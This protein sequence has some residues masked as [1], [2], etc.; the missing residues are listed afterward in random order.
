MKQVIA[1]VAVLAMG[2][3]ASFA[4]NTNG[5]NARKP[6]RVPLSNTPIASSSGNAPRRRVEAGAATSPEAAFSAPRSEV[7]A[8]RGRTTRI[9][10]AAQRPATPMMPTELRQGSTT[11]SQAVAAGIAI[12]PR[13]P[14][15]L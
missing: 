9:A 5:R 3:V 13:S 8:L 10:A 14:A 12:L 2:V 4:R 11:I 1:L 15:K 6:M 7:G